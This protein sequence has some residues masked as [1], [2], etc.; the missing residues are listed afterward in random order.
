VDASSVQHAEATGRYDAS[1]KYIS[2][3]LLS[4]L[5]VLLLSG[6][7]CANDPASISGGDRA[8]AEA[9]Y[10]RL[11][12]LSGDWYLVRG[13]R[14]GVELESN[15]DEPFMTY[16]VSSAGHSVI[17]ELFAG[18]P[19]EM[20]S[21]YYLDSGRLMMDH[22]CSLGNQPRMVAVAGPQDEI[23]FKLLSVSNMDDANELHISSHS[24]EFDGPDEL[25]VRWGATENQ[26]PMGGSFYTVKR[27]E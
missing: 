5:T 9:D 3:A 11:K 1:M 12:T 26:K 27:A 19:N 24:V 7:I 2:T 21:V 15:F 17:E 23:P 18:K 6:C 20:T 14:L 8:M 16:S 10:E 4:I 22:Y 13:V 25:T